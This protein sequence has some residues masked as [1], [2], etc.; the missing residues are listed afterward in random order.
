M[1]DKLCI[2]Q[3]NFERSQQQLMQS[4]P[5]AQMETFTIV[6]GWDKPQIPTPEELTLEKTKELITE[7]NDFSFETIKKEFVDQVLKDPMMMPLLISAIAHDY[8]YKK[9]KFTEEQF[10]AALFEHKIYEDPYIAQKLE[11]KQFELMMY[12]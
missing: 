7:A 10:K 6:L 1:F 12:I 9:H 4:D 3:E 8:T 5:G 11:Q 2:S